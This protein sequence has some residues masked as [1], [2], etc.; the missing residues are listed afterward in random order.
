MAAPQGYPESRRLTCWSAICIFSQV[1]ETSTR[2]KE[3]GPVKSLCKHGNVVL[4]ANKIM[5]FAGKSLSLE[6]F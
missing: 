1:G 5:V 3:V 6:C 2:E 4:L